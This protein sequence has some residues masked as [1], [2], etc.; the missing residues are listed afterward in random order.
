MT[1]YCDGKD[2]RVM[3]LA[4]GT[5]TTIR[6]DNECSVYSEMILRDIKHHEG[7]RV[8]NNNINNLRYADDT[9]LIADSE[10]NLQNILTPITV[11]SENKGLQLNANKTEYKVIS[12]QSDIP[13]CNV[14]CKRERIKQVDSFK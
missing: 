12:K 6:I 11:E 1:V 9:V 2:L 13:V 3:K 10:E 14:L 8:G 5:D 7:V 4:L